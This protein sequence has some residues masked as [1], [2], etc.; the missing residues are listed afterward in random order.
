[1]KG[2]P[3][4]SSTPLCGTSFTTPTITGQSSGF[5]G[6]PPKMNLPLTA[7]PLGKNFRAKL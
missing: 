6:R 1:M 7:E 4:F 5:S 2:L 3:L